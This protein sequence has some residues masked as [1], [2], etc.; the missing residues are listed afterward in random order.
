MTNHNLLASYQGKTRILMHRYGERGIK[1]EEILEYINATLHKYLPS[2]DA[3][4]IMQDYG[5]VRSRYKLE[6]N[7]DDPNGLFKIYK[8]TPDGYL[9]SGSQRLIASFWVDSNDKDVTPKEF[10]ANQ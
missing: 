8:V 4:A 9:I 3:E 2:D 7:E 1:E 10:L 5:T 6:K